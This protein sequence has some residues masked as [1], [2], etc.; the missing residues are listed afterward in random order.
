[1]SVHFKVAVRLGF[2]LCC[3][4]IGLC[5]GLRLVLAQGET[6]SLWQSFLSGDGI[7]SGN[8]LSIYAAQD[9]TLWFG[10]DA[11]ASQYDGSWRTLMKADGLPSDRVRAITQTKDS[12]LWF[13]T[14]AGLARR[15]TDGSCCR[16]WTVADGLPDG[17][18][19]AL[20]A[21]AQAPLGS[22]TPG[23]WVGTAKGLAYADGE[24]VVIDSPVPD[25]NIQALAVTSDGDLLASVAGQ[26]VWQR[27]QA[28]GWQSLGDS[29]LVAE[30]PL[31]LW[32]GQDGRIWAGTENGMVFYR[33]GVWQRLPLLSD[34][35]GLK[36]L[37]ILQDNDGGIW[38]GT[39]NGVFLDA[40]AAPGGVPVVQYQAQRDGLVNDHVR[41]IASDRDGGRWFGT[42][43]GVSRYAGGSWQD[44]RDPMVAGQRINT[45]LVD[46]AG[47]T[48]VGM[49][50]SGLSLCD[51][52]RWQR[53]TGLKGLPDK[54]IVMLFEDDAGRMWVSTGKGVGYFKPTDLQQFNN[55]AGA[56]LV[57]A[58][59]QDDKAT[60]WLAA[61]D[62]LY[63]WSETGGLQPISEFAGKRVNA[64][65][66]A[67]DGTFWAGTQ[68]DGLLHLVGDTWQPV[69]DAASG[70]LRFN[71]IVV[72][73][74]S[75][76]AD[77]SLW[78]GTYNDGLWRYRSGQWERSDANLA[79]PK[80]LSLSAA[81]QQLWV[82][83]RQ[84]LG[85]YD[86]RTWQSYDGEV[87]SN[88]GVLALAPSNDHTLWIGTMAGLVH[89]RP[90]TT[91][92]WAVIRAFN[93]TPVTGSVTGLNEDVLQAVRV[94]GGD[95]ATRAEDLLFL[96]QID[97]LD[98]VPQV[99]QE[100]L[101]TG[102]SSANLS[103]GL[104]TIRV[105]AR[106][107]A[108]NYS[109]PA[110]AQFFLPRF[111]TLPGGK[112]VRA[113]L[114][115]PMLG[116]GVVVLGLLTVSAM[117]S[118]RSRARNRQLTDQ[119][120][121][122][123]REAMA[124]RFNPYISGEP[125]RQ[126]AMFFG[127]DELLHRIFNA[128]HQNSIMIYGERR[129][130][131]TTLLY[132]LAE[133]LRQADDPEWAFIPVYMDL[134][135]T[136]QDRFFHVLIETIWGVLQAYVL[137]RPSGL[138][139]IESPPEGYT[140]RE[141]TADLRLI[142]DSVKDAVAPRKARVILLLDEMDVVSSYDTVVQQQLRRIF[143]SPL[144]A[145]LGAVVAGIQISRTWDRLESPWYNMFNE[146]PLEL[147]TAE[148]ARE[149]LVEPVRGIYEWDP[150]AIEFVIQQSEGYPHRLQQYALESVNQMSAADRTRITLEDV[151][152]AQEII[153]RAQT[154]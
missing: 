50:N 87:L 108:F 86:G 47:R 83:T 74:I 71:D 120:A 55:V 112:R 75:E 79:S 116:L 41:A 21:G 61:G 127:R 89:Y 92:P 147:F 121:E 80:I 66:Q 109:T 10:T 146:M 53:V 81:G 149:L 14:D 45:T 98:A 28:G 32:A 95:L 78:V 58:F 4:L 91:P 148:Q 102:Y 24:Q 16:R 113:D 135:G 26:G 68:T 100:P 33:D 130:G 97:G 140:D 107:S 36:V 54:R 9:G 125:V 123:Q 49:E 5:C 129:T 139:F 56:G 2:G 40:D 154:I 117:T 19:H 67:A 63:H 51:G 42:I 124:R 101:I 70:K 152:A 8:V 128:L 6:N 138:L 150:E 15:A 131:K 94:A 18:V 69:T 103:P 118:L 46:R 104:H 141:F 93:L 85:A 99:H 3:V 22:K 30:G 119:V 106:D 7:P 96:T 59:E 77:G 39:E 144:A 12:A 114:L 1:M 37:A 20:A 52:V 29:S 34:D 17:D 64:I 84:G 90:E 145:N 13:G 82:G 27:G 35:T 60:V 110:E 111:V 65:H 44:I 72:N 73:G 133:Q 25:A 153:E 142:L 143:M 38:A 137:D 11:G 76:T 136:S 126:P 132:Q 62:G 151:K 57:Y 31:A 115:Y 43:A 134:E 23:V 88:P 48:W 122:R 105:Q